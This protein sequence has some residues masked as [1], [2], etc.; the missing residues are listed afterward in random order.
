MDPSDE[1][2]ALSVPD[3]PMA[4]KTLWNDPLVSPPP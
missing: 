3:I 1:R 2:E 4:V